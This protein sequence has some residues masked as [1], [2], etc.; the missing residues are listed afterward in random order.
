[1]PKSQGTQQPQHPEDSQAQEAAKEPRPVEKRSNKVAV[2]GFAGSTLNE[3]PVNDQSWE[4]WGLNQL[5]MQLPRY[6]LWFDLHPRWHTY[7]DARHFE[8]LKQQTKPILMQDHFHDIPCSVAYPKEDILRI[9]GTYFTSS[10]AWM[11]ALAIAQ[12]YQTIGIWGVDMLGDG[13]YA[14]QRACCDYY[15]GLARGAGIDVIIPKDS[16]LCRGQELYGYDYVEPFSARRMTRLNKRRSSL[17]EQ[18]DK[19]LQDIYMHDGAILEVQE[20][21]QVE[22]D[23]NW[24][25]SRLVD[26]K[27]KRE[28]VLKGLYT[29]DGAL[30]ELAATSNYEK[31]YK[32]GGA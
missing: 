15:I 25:A 23:D 26:L 29:V 22:H 9:F 3:A 11:L 5:W 28:D 30:Q 19:A 13:E 32:R 4:V 20:W 14:F 17:Q 1:M 8:W 27:T 10:I 12:K 16:A 7:T 24:K 6:D 21:T 18:R 2:L 31:H